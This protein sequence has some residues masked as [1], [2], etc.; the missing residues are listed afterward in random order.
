[1]FVSLPAPTP[2]DADAVCMLDGL[3]LPLSH[4]PLSLRTQL[5]WH[6]A[7]QALNRHGM[8]ALPRSLQTHQA[9]LVTMVLSGLLTTMILTPR[10][11]NLL[12]FEH[13]FH[14]SRV[15]LRPGWHDYCPALGQRSTTQ[16]P[17]SKSNFR[18]CLFL[19]VVLLPF[20]L[21]K[22]KSIIP[23]VKH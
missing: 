23:K 15:F 16:F 11:S 4:S 12:T 10:F 1:M 5:Y 9:S 20:H 6:G 3:F 21:D 17:N 14:M 18:T 7:S 2:S 13:C 22:P 19:K 8:G